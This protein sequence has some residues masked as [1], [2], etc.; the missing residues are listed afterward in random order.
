MLTCATLV[1][2]IGIV[3]RSPRSGDR[4][5]EVVHQTTSS[6]RRTG[7]VAPG[8]R[9]L[10]RFPGSTDRVMVDVGAAGGQA[11]RLIDV[12]HPAWRCGE[13]AVSHV[14]APPPGNVRR[15]RRGDLLCRARAVLTRIH[16]RRPVDHRGFDQ[17]SGGYV[18][19]HISVV[20]A[21]NR[22]CACGERCGHTG[23][24]HVH[25]VAIDCPPTGRRSRAGL[26]RGNERARRDNIRLVAPIEHRPTAAERRQ[27]RDIVC[28]WI[29][30]HRICRKIGRPAVAPRRRDTGAIILGSPYCD[31][32]LGRGRAAH[33]VEIDDAIRVVV[34]ARVGR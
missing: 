11:C 1:G 10:E 2:V 13:D 33:R 30:A 9:H 18:A 16:I 27:T 12:S 23:S 17:C 3:C 29:V 28:H 22:R 5:I 6:N 21:D 4:K 24:A 7:I 20:L 8:Q 31:T 15:S 32:V 19:L 25:I 34:D 26:R 14:D